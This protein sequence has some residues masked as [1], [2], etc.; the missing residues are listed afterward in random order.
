MAQQN[1]RYSGYLSESTNVK[2]IPSRHKAR[3]VKVQKTYSGVGALNLLEVQVFDD[4]NI[5]RALT[6]NGAT[7]FQSSTFIWDGNLCP[8]S[9]AID[10]STTEQFGTVCDGMSHTMDD[11]NPW[12]MVDL[13][14]S[15]EISK[16][17]I[18]NRISCCQERLSYAAVSLL[19][20]NS[21]LIRQVDSIGDA[22]N[23]PTV[24]L[25]INSFNI[26]ANPP[27]NSIWLRVT[28]VGSVMTA[29]YK[30]EW[31]S[32]WV[33]FG[34][35]ISISA[36]KSTG[37]YVGLAA[38]AHDNNSQQMMTTLKVSEF[39]L[40]RTCSSASI[41]PEQ[42][43]QA[44]NC[45]LGLRTSTCYDAG[46]TKA[47]RVKIQ[48]PATEYLHLAEVKVF[49]EYGNNVALNKPAIMSSVYDVNYFPY[50]GDGNDGLVV[51]S[52]FHTDIEEGPWWEVDLEEPALITEIHIFNR[53]LDCN[54]SCQ[55]R[56]NGAIVSLIDYKGH[57][58]DTRDIGVVVIQEPQ[59]PPTPIDLTFNPVP[60][61]SY[62]T[63]TKMVK[64]QLTGTD[65]LHLTE[66]QV[67]DEAGVNRALNKPTTM[68]SMYD[69]SLADE[70]PGQAVDGITSGA[71][72]FHTDIEFGA[73]WQ[74]DLKQVVN[75][76]Q[77]VLYNRQD[78]DT[79]QKRLSNAIVSLIDYQGEVFN[80]K[81]VGDTTGVTQLV[82]NFEEIKK[83][84]LPPKETQSVS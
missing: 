22:R 65:Y 56:A 71:N 38:T 19:D 6:S 27:S 51:D 14:A 77:I 25:N 30:E 67:F 68:S 66:V 36:I 47:D 13:G 62:L 61:G 52:M 45:E 17:V 50:A 40:E 31:S 81:N 8:A 18:W 74:V 72:Y 58:F 9:F 35:Q 34:K 42:C 80:Q 29:F 11:P 23:V 73:W 60:M 20:E 12:W 43:D 28:K 39:N 49:N 21:N 83:S 3:F 53:K 57:I 10:G 54:E 15:Y 41:T 32:F 78:C 5:N 64:I 84:V 59:A 33:P 24:D 69:S 63:L 79:C 70:S 37:Y 75:V 48:L 46:S 55:A 4:A 44:A 16:V 82:L 1:R 2:S 26:V 76:K 7:A